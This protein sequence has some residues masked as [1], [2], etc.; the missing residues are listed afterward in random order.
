MGKRLSLA[1][2]IG[3][4]LAVFSMA[5]AAAADDFAGCLQ[6]GEVI[7]YADGA[8][9]NDSGSVIDALQGKAQV[10]VMPFD[11]NSALDANKT[12]QSLA[13]SNGIPELIVIRDNR[14]GADSFGVYSQS[15]KDVEIL[16]AMNSSK[17]SDGGETITAADI[18]S[19]YDAQIAAPPG[20]DGGFSPLALILPAAAII[21]VL[22][23]G[24]L[25][26]KRINSSR[27]QIASDSNRSPSISLKDQRSVEISEDLRRELD[28]LAATSKRYRGS[29]ERKLEEA[30]GLIDSALG[31]TYELFKRI[32]RKKD[33]Q[34][35][36]IAQRRYLD[37]VKKLNS[38]LSS[39]YFEDIVRKPGLW[40]GA[41]E[42]REDVLTALKSVDRQIIENIKQ[43]NSS[44]EI[45]F[46][47]AVDSLIGSEP[48]DVD[49]V[50]RGQDD[51]PR[52]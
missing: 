21:A 49:D 5:P 43:V 37:T 32:D 39:D 19:I 44:K 15:G 13:E 30:A 9:I 17:Q 46:R 18:G 52:S 16:T 50:F 11:V 26:L 7:C 4:L 28:S 23:G 38:A 48:M 2:A 10:V 8:T 42:K 33:R 12:A 36:E 40:D 20:A 3:M 45:E 47:I 1:G 35:R 41:E 51:R 27:R 6:G 34:N 24:G 29:D 25:I 31:H 22:G 14:S